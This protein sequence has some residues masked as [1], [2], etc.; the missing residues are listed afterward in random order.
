[1]PNEQKPSRKKRRKHL[2]I[3]HGKPVR[4]TA[5]G[6]VYLSADGRHITYT[7]DAQPIDSAA[8]DKLQFPADTGR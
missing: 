1:M 7:A 3:S 5:P 8:T 6:W 4:V 2:R